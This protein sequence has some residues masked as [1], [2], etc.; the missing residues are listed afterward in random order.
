ML[1]SQAM[2]RLFTALLSLALLC[3]QSVLLPLHE[4]R[5]ARQEAGH[6]LAQ[7]GRSPAA[8]PVDTHE[9]HDEAECS[10]CLGSAQQRLSA[11]AS[12]AA[13]AAAVFTPALSARDLPPAAAPFLASAA[14]RGP[15]SAS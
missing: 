15:P 3:G 8:A 9:H 4:S 1:H 7:A 2:R 10:L 13:A 5:V 11:S 6:H 14:P 12:A